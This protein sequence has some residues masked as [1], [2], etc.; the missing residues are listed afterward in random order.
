MLRQVVD[1]RFPYHLLRFQVKAV[2]LRLQG[3][4]ASL[5]VALQLNPLRLIPRESV[6]HLLWLH[7]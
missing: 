3:A 4:L 5:R 1:R 7:F 2:S 6:L